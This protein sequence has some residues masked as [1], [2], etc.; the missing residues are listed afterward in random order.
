MS[1]DLYFYKR[2]DSPLTEE[3]V[4]AYLTK[5]LPFNISKSNRQWDYE[6]SE[7]GVYFVIEWVKLKDSDFL[8]E[9][10]E[11]TCINF[12]FSLNF[13]R[14]R[15]FGLESFPIIDK[16]VDDLDLFI[17]DPQDFG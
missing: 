14:P 6:N 4:A 5:N 8:E 2:K 7:T 15:F 10:E 12:T 16:L 3:V 13:F 11:F 17:F 1:F 9:F